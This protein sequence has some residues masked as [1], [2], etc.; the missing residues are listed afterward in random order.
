MDRLVGA[1]AGPALAVSLAGCGHGPQ[2][3]SPAGRTDPCAVKSIE[4]REPPLSLYVSPDSRKF[5]ENRKDA[6]GIYQVYVGDMRSQGSS[7]C[8]SCSPAPGGPGPGAHKLM[9]VWHPS[10]RWLFVGGEYP[11]KRPPWISP[12]QDLALMQSGTNLNMYVTR[13]EG[14]PWYLLADFGGAGYTGPAVTADGRAYYA[15]IVDG[16]ILAYTFG[17]WLL[18]RADFVVNG[19]G[20]PSLAN[21][22][23]VSPD[24]TNWIEPGNAS[25]DGRY[26]LLTLDTG[27]SP[28]Q[29]AGMDQ[30][31]LELATGRLTNLN[32]TPKEWDEHGFFAPNSRKIVFMSSHPYP[33]YDASTAPFGIWGLKTEF[34]LMDVDGSNL[35]QL[36]HFGQPGYPE[37]TAETSVA[38]V[39]FFSGDGSQLIAAQLLTGAHFPDQVT[40]ILTFAGRCGGDGGT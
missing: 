18:K 10:S 23:D 16:N 12:E 29:A 4:K 37:S 2:E 33:Q 13:P 40:W 25:P 17:K 9:V 14:G 1:L 28:T 20:V 34:M 6:N 39:A 22:L 5:V 35:V 27:L 21:T 38:A 32:K 19:A 11:H 8:I 7:V 26:L 36:T 24:N 30:W 31:L 3:P 15:Q